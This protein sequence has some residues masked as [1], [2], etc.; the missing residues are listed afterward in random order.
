MGYITDLLSFVKKQDEEEE[1]PKQSEEDKKKLYA[2]QDDY[3]DRK[4]Q[5]YDEKDVA[6]DENYIPYEGEL[7]DVGESFEEWWDRKKEDWHRPN[8]VTLEE[9]KHY[10]HLDEVAEHEDTTD[11][12]VHND[13]IQDASTAISKLLRKAKFPFIQK[14]FFEPENKAGENEVDYQNNPLPKSTPEQIEHQHHGL[15]H[16][17]IHGGIRDKNGNIDHKSENFDHASI[18]GGVLAMGDYGRHNGHH[19]PALNN[20]DF[21]PYEWEDNPKM[22]GTTSGKIQGMNQPKE[23]AAKTRGTN[24]IPALVEQGIHVYV[25]TEKP[26]AD[27]GVPITS[28]RGAKWWIRTPENP[29]NITAERAVSMGLF[30]DV[31]EAMEHPQIQGEVHRKRVDSM[32]DAS[33]AALGTAVDPKEIEAELDKEQQKMSDLYQQILEGKTIADLED[34]SYINAN[35]VEEKGQFISFKK[36]A[37]GKAQGVTPLNPSIQGPGST[38]PGEPVQIPSNAGNVRISTD[39][40]SRIQ[41]IY[42]LGDNE[43][44]I[45]SADAVQRKTY[46]KWRAIALANKYIDTMADK[47]I[48]LSKTDMNQLST[49]DQLVLVTYAL[50]MR[51]GTNAFNGDKLFASKLGIK[52]S[53]MATGDQTG[54]DKPNAEYIKG[55]PKGLEAQGQQD[56]FWGDSAT[57]TDQ[58]TGLNHK[59]SWQITTDKYGNSKYEVIPAEVGHETA[60]GVQGL[61][62]KHIQPKIGKNGQWEGA[63]LRYNAKGHGLV[64]KD[65]TDPN[66]LRILQ[67]GYDDAMNNNVAHWVATG[68]GTGLTPRRPYK[69][70]MGRDMDWP[71]LGSAEYP[72]D[73]PKSRGRVQTERKRL[74]SLGYGHQ[75]HNLSQSH[76][77]VGDRNIFGFSTQDKNNKHLQ[78][79]VGAELNDKLQDRFQNE[80][81]GISFKSLRSAVGNKVATKG[82]E[83][84]Q[85][86][87][88][89]YFDAVSEAGLEHPPY[90][91]KS[92]E[93]KNLSETERKTETDNKKKLDDVLGLSRYQA[94]TRTDM[95][96]NPVVDPD[97]GEE[98]KD[99]VYMEPFAHLRDLQTHITDEVGLELDHYRTSYI[100]WGDAD[101]ESDHPQFGELK[102]DS[103]GNPQ[104]VRQAT[105][106]TAEQNYI[107][108]RRVFH[109]YKTGQA[110]RFIKSGAGYQFRDGTYKKKARAAIQN[111]WI[112]N[113]RGSTDSY[114]NKKKLKKEG[115]GLGGD[116]GGTV[117]TSSDAGVFTPTHS[118][119]GTRKKNDK[120]KRTGIDRLADFVDG[121]SP[122]R[123]MVKATPSFSLELVNWVKDELRKTEQSQM[124]GQGAIPQKGNFRQQKSGETINSQPPRLLNGQNFYQK[125]D[126]LPEDKDAV[127][128][129]DSEPDDTTAVEQNRETDRIKELYDDEEKDRPNDTGG[130]DMASPEGITGVSPN[131]RLA[132]PHSERGTGYES[133]ALHQGGSKD[134][135][136]GQVDDPSDVHEDEE[137]VKS[138]IEELEL[139]KEYYDSQI[140]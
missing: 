56:T 45:Y 60:I 85:A 136:R 71:T 88:Q 82:L 109:G 91:S 137:F 41:A 98:I 75:G 36:W 73:D 128:E 106:K 52:S 27:A 63:V 107:D 122:E 18:S 5:Y 89:K 40:H 95:F 83:T 97:T 64:T 131:I 1:A 48:E 94:T 42:T 38:N 30:K 44:E 105:G 61:K 31:E 9:F 34:I 7:D 16:E 81:V 22:P 116:G 10:H 134:K 138:F 74:G 79:V 130:T 43:Y 135:E 111:A 65:V 114:N 8:K 55:L 13:E 15:S 19:D 126:E 51:H 29:G 37:D 14:I 96:G 115:T 110:S 87:V 57:L 112:T 123:K 46:V 93:W 77:E 100:R 140:K 24:P 129:F 103:S 53:T 21:V 49:Q 132:V 67:K 39:P 86:Q 12:G 54:F 120:K 113:P 70:V 119:R 84:Y 66:A 76:I 99:A 101:G 139:V 25:S 108:M 58:T 4:V 3:I 125:D 133:D 28:T 23:G 33:L 50:G 11:R 59:K 118:E 17:E 69:D 121:N 26:P 32:A 104:R 20:A 124:S 102:L 6:Y 90:N 35:G 68:T 117:F 80:D 47:L 92:P 62:V 127:V 72:A 78:N 2:A